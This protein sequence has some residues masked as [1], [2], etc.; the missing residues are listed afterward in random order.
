VEQ[1]LLTESAFETFCQQQLGFPPKF[2]SAMTGLYF[3]S[4]RIADVSKDVDQLLGRPPMS[5]EEWMAANSHF[6]LAQV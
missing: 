2:A 6:F 5:I 4:S 3:A 1:T